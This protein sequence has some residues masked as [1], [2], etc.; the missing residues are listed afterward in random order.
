MKNTVLLLLAA[1]LVY[2]VLV[3]PNY[4]GAVNLSAL[5]HFP[6]EL[7]VVLLVMLVVGGRRGVAVGLTVLL[8]VVTVLKLADMS[9]FAAYNRAFNPVLDAFLIHAGIGLLGESIGK[10]L[11]YLALGVAGLAII[12]LFYMLLRSL[13]IWGGVAVSAKGRAAAA[14]GAIVFGGWALADAG[15]HL[16]YW[17]FENS[18]YGTAATSRLVMAR[19]TSMQATV[20]DL[21]QFNLDA[22]QD[23]YADATGLLDRLQGRDVIVIYIESYGR[24]SFDNPLYAPMHAGTLDRAATA[25]IDAGFV[26]KSGWLTSPTAGGKAG[27]RMARCPV[28]CGRRIRD[29]TAP[30]WPAGK[31]ACFTLPKMQVFAQ[32]R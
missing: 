3:L 11:T 17:T 31:R 5:G 26:A 28:G 1:V 29:G 9:M 32:R 25:V 8:L 22:R 20:V 6:L 19:G 12:V 24:A 21:A 13:R 7:P 30:C 15:H 10:P 2:F 27:W 4:P 16:K 23:I 18:P 14:V